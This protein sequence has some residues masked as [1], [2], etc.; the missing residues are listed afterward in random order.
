MR[1]T[2]L[3][4]LVL[5]KMQRQ[6]AILAFVCTVSDRHRTGVDS[7]P[8]IEKRRRYSSTPNTPPPEPFPPCHQSPVAG[9][10]FGS[11]IQIQCLLKQRGDR[12]KDK[13]CHGVALTCVRVLC[14]PR[15]TMYWTTATLE[16]AMFLAT[17]VHVISG[18][19]IGVLAVMA[20]K[21]MRKQRRMC[22][23]SY[24]PTDAPQN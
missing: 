1:N 18:I 6:G 14:C 21:Q 13:L 7:I 11:Q 15:T 5:Q 4:L 16:A 23:H 17:K 19:V 12:G 9:V 10:F 3:V 22:K 20:A 8:P 24:V 2:L